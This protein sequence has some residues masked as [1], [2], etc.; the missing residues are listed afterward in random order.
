MAD[1]MVSTSEPM[2]APKTVPA[3]PRDEAANADVAEARALPATCGPLRPKSLGA[4]GAGAGSISGAGSGVER[5]GSV[6]G[7]NGIKTRLAGCSMGVVR[8]AAVAMP[9][10]PP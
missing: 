6:G 7:A 4:A 9:V 2:R 1:A 3:T 10:E 5:R 8:A